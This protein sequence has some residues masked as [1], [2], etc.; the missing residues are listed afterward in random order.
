MRKR[1]RASEAAATHRMGTGTHLWHC[2]GLM[3]ATGAVVGFAAWAAIALWFQAPGGPLLR[4]VCIGGWLSFALAALLALHRAHGMLALMA[5]ALAVGGVL[6][7][8]HSLKPSNDRLWA[9]D[10]ARTTSGAVHGDLVT[11]SNV[12]NF[13]WRSETDYTQRWETRSYDLRRL[14]SLDMITSYWAGPAI[15]HV[16]LSFGFDDGQ[17]VVFSVEIRRQKSQTFSEIGGFFKEFELSVIAADE[18]DVI[19]V[20]TNIRGEDDY[21]YCIRLP[22]QDIRLLFLSYLK[23]TNELVH[24]PRFYNTITVNCTTLVYH[25][26]ERIVGRLPFSYRLLLSG[27]LPGYVYS[28]GGL[29][30]RYTLEQLRAFGRITQRAQE[31]DRSEFFSRDIRRGIPPLQSAPAGS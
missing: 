14:Q 2:T 8:W 24:T 23:Q 30:Q 18:R 20:R 31:S 6:L 7:W 28:V 9:D 1:P 17:H 25:M 4:G 15:A 22:L 13:D 12:R 27:Y 5:F 10:V 21:L 11:L 29:D 19:R 3:L 26:M 16:L